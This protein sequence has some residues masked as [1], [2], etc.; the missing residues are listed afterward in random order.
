MLM[1]SEKSEIGNSCDV[2][3]VV[4]A[5]NEAQGIVG[6]LESI[7]AQKSELNFRVVV[8]DDGS[9]DGTSD[10]V[11]EIF[12]K[13]VSII[14]QDNL[15]RGAARING[16]SSTSTPYVAMVDS[17]IRLPRNWLQTCWENL[18]D[19]MAIGGIAVPDGD[20][21]AIARIFK[22]D[23][24]IRLGSIPTTGSNSFFNRR[25]LLNVGN[26][27]VTRLGEDFRLHKLFEAHNYPMR[28]V[29]TLVVQHIENK[30]YL[31]SIKWLFSSGKD[32]TSL[33][34][35]FKKTRLPDV[36]SALFL[37][38]VVA[39][40]VEIHFHKY[41]WISL[42]PSFILLVG[43]G[44]LYSKFHLTSKVFWALAAWLPNSL[45]MLSYL[46]GRLVGF[47]TFLASRF[48]PDK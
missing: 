11:S 13:R 42:L 48:T 2:T 12:G 14:K 5:F 46:S 9:T 16:I 20:C 3:F 45:L 22:L 8:V 36:L 27:W 31:Q 26:S 18:N 23:P 17:D 24:K 35:E 30:S 6:C 7:L 41:L 21:S 28:S 43:A 10:L 1:N 44:H 39:L 38:L 47:L 37:A 4:I 19:S 33:W 25:A 29:S 40:P 32:A 15:G 34:F